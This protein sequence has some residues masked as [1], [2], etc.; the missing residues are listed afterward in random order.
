[1]TY[2][3]FA[4]KMPSF[5]ILYVEDDL[6]IR[7]YFVEFLKRYCKNIYESDNAEE[8][9]KLYHKYNP[10]ILLL[11][12][13]LPAM[14]GIELAHIIRQSDKKIRILMSTAYTNTEF[15]LKAIEL[16]I[17]RYLIKPVT[18]HD[19]FE[20][21]EKAIKEIE[22]RT[23]KNSVDLGEGFIYDKIDNSITHD[24]KTTILRK[25]EV[26]LLDFFIKNSNK[27][28]DYNTLENSIWQNNIMT[29]DAIRG[30]IK[31]L[32]KKT[33]HEL[34][35]NISGIGYRFRCDTT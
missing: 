2:K 10:D 29:Q 32:R 7:G 22:E 28:I 5:T 11:D 34:I 30:Q 9:L 1:M 17:T 14:S 21:F 25:R 26:E 33:Y 23:P 20:A 15:M 19:L 6:G 4:K 24:K 8:A 13:N 12:I 35:E 16:D 18:S 31:N 27:I 3:N